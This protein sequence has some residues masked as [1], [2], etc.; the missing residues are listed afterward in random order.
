[1][2]VLEI[3]AVLLI[4]TAIAAL[5][6]P[7]FI[8]MK[9]VARKQVLGSIAVQLERSSRF[10]RANTFK[11]GMLEDSDRF[12]VVCFNGYD[13]P[14]CNKQGYAEDIVSTDMVLVQRGFPYVAVRGVLAPVSMLGYS[15]TADTYTNLKIKVNNEVNLFETCGAYCNL[16][17]L[18]DVCGTDICVQDSMKGALVFLHGMSASERC[19]VRYLHSGG[20][21]PEIEVETS[22]C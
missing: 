3:I 10:I 16:E 6:A 7:K 13:N 15:Y 17:D 11:H 19:Y 21:V 2:A 5:T 14:K 22:G 12:Y 4:V 9:S 18:K 8:H 20:K 1:M